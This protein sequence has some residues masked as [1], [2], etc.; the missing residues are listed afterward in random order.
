MLKQDY[1]D[2]FLLFCD[3]FLSKVVGV[4]SWT[5]DCTKKRVSEM[6]TVSDEAFAYLLIENYWDT[7]AS[8]DLVAYNNEADFE[9]NSIKKKKGRL[10]G[11]KVHLVL[12]VLVD[13]QMKAAWGSVHCIRCMQIGAKMVRWLKSYINHI[14][15]QT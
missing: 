4:N 3:F 9:V 13:G 8:V 2:C 15:L 1:R 7:W 12:D 11:P 5:D 10:L 6:A 14:V